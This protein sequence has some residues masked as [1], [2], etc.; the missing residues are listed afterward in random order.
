[1]AQPIRVVV[2]GAAGQIAY[3]LLYMIARGEVF[4]KDQPLILHLLDIPPMMG[5][6][7]GVV[8]ELADCALPLLRQVIP[9][10]DPAVGFKDVSAA[11][12]VG[13][14]PR[15]EG[16]ER[17]DLLSANVKIFKA[18]GQAIDQHARK[19]I[20]V[21]VVGNPANTN[22]LV[23]SH[24]APSIPRENFTAMTRLDQNRATAQIA[25][26]LGVPINAVKNVVIWGNH[27]STQFPDPSNGIV[28]V[29][30]AV[31]RV[32]DAVNDAA[33]LQGQ[34]VETVQKRGAAVIAAR[35]M[36]SA[37]SA[38]KAACDHMHDWWNGTASG[39]FV[40]MGVISDGSYGA[41]KDVVFSF[42]VEIS[43][44]KWKIV[45]GLQLDDFAKSKLAL[46]GKELEEEK[47]EAMAVCSA[48]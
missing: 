7:E 41:P 32:W 15:K 2:T 20:K 8:M 36:S 46:T 48:D 44:G 45:Q 22:A 29:D 38:A 1:M 39:Q 35:K 25:A 5:V 31:K 23:C 24:Y 47:G 16:M 27:S 34:F 10:A 9:T 33:F 13:A 42:P 30:G 6:L 4:G 12:L 28:E 17:K 18:Q 43:N 19:D 14:M 26:K 3:S 37:M 40:S 21:L 11:F